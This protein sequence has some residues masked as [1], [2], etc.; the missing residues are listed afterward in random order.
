[1]E[2]GHRGAVQQ[3]SWHLLTTEENPGKPQ[4]ENR[5][6]AHSSATSHCFKWGPF[7]RNEVG[8]IT[9]PAP[10]AKHIRVR[11]RVTRRPAFGGHVFLFWSCPPVLQALKY[12]LKSPTFKKLRLFKTQLFISNGFLIVYA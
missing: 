11:S 10:I 2:W 7:P 1:M 6:G 3:I 9:L 12:L 5:R 4:L 8:R